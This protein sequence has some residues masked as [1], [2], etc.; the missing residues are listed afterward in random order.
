MNTLVTR[1]RLMLGAVALLALLVVP[2]AVAGTGGDPQATASGVQSKIKKLKKQVKQANRAIDALEQQ[3][4][5]LQGEQGGSR[6]PTGPAGGDLAGG[7][8]NPQI[9][10]NTVGNAEL[11]GDSVTEPKI[12]ADAVGNA[13]LQGDSVTGSEIALR[14]VD[15]PDLEFSSVEEDHLA[16]G[17]VGS[18]ALIDIQRFQSTV[19]IPPSGGVGEVGQNCPSGEVVSGGAVFDFPSGDITASYPLSGSW[20]AE[21]QNNGTVAQNLTVWVLCLPSEP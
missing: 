10:A 12:A 14:A 13:E 11:Q 6:P 19:S 7:Y 1:T 9:G 5:G 4:A 21:G 15:T 8:P 3:V 2:F 17:A 16:D 18:G 20:F